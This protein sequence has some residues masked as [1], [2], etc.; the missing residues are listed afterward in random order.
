V[1]L[2]KRRDKIKTRHLK[3]KKL[4]RLL[5]YASSHQVNVKTCH[6]TEKKDGTS[7]NG[8]TDVSPKE[9]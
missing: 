9:K 4:D 2:W 1:L 7:S 3:I 8:L 6:H 5:Q